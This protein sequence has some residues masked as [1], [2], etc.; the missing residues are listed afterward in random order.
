M[1]VAEAKEHSH[2]HAHMEDC[3]SDDEVVVDTSN[4]GSDDTAILNGT[5]K[6]QSRSEKKARRQLLKLGLKPV[7]GITRVTVRRSRSTVFALQNADVY[8]SPA[9]NTY[10]IFGDPRTDD[11]SSQLKSTAVEQ[12]AKLA[13][14]GELPKIPGLNAEALQA[15]AAATA[16]SNSGAASPPKQGSPKG[17]AKVESAAA[18]V[19]S[20]EAG[21]LDEKDIEL[22]MSQG[23][24]SRERAIA[25][26][27]ENNNDM[28]NAIMSL[29]I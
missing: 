20:A 29:T 27:R 11:L 1:V 19:A 5:R 26:L 14:N 4:M 10:I 25:V 15:A 12:I 2:D 18:P 13:A 24:V 23:G 3:H 9:S 7:S 6:N 21:D 28:V 17:K 16:A 8:Y 22:V